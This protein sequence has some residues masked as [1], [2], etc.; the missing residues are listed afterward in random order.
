MP[1]K[2]AVDP[3]SPAADQQQ[4]N[5]ISLSTNGNNTSAVESSSSSS[6]AKSRPSPDKP[7][8]A[9]SNAASGYV[10]PQPSYLFEYVLD[11][12]YTWIAKFYPRAITPNQLTVF[13]IC[14]TCVA[15]LLYFALVMYPSTNDQITGK[16]VGNAGFN[17]VLD[18]RF[19]TLDNYAKFN[20]KFDA[21]VAKK[22]S[23]PA[24]P[25][26][27]FSHMTLEPGA[28]VHVDDD[29]KWILILVGVLNVIYMI[30]DNTDGK[31]ARRYNM[32]STVGEYLDHGLD[33]IAFSLSVFVLTSLLFERI[34]VALIVQMFLCVLLYFTHSVNYT[35]N[36]M[37]WG[38]RFV[39]VDEGTLLFSCGPLFVGLFTH[40]AERVFPIGAIRTVQL[41]AFVL[42]LSQFDTF[43][44]YLRKDLRALNIG[45]LTQLASNVVIIMCLFYHDGGMAQ[46]PA[47]SS[48]QFFHNL[49]SPFADWDPAKVAKLNG[50]TEQPSGAVVFVAAIVR[51]FGIFIRNILTCYPALVGIMVALVAS[52]AAH[53]AVAAKV[54]YYP[55]ESW[56]PLGAIVFGT[57][58]F[59]FSPPV[60]V[61][62]MTV[63]HAVQIRYNLIALVSPAHMA[64]LLERKK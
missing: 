14:C 36:E 46:G 49:L 10:P 44:K 45:L 53:I 35:S 4:Q 25:D 15:S 56:T 43:I 62:F 47:A 52:V 42:V 61:L 24:L 18:F 38:N 20:P 60:A 13:G 6:A 30:A 1:A 32:C 27:M 9:I 41:V 3:A 19:T 34:A 7:A 40:A 55:K 12:F 21:D 11:P 58:I 50:S 17:T 59:V 54:L 5:A 23:T 39:S 63:C 16:P 26:F 8:G 22:Y 2:K 33:S 37:I 51:C 29:V 48:L 64:H 28:I 57:F 31:Q